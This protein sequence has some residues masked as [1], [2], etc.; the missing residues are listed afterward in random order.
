MST[1]NEGA[2][3]ADTEVT[4]QSPADDVQQTS[5][6]ATSQETDWQ[7]EPGT[8]DPSKPKPVAKPDVKYQG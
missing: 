6:A 5:E 8:L 3:P 2:T 1:G 4:G 7:D